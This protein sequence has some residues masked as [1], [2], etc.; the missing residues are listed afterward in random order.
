MTG[1]T[2]ATLS[3]GWAGPGQG[4][5]CWPLTLAWGQLDPGPIGLGQGR[6]RANPDPSILPTYK[7]ILSTTSIRN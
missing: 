5:F 7:T 1:S 4:H 3:R 2:V 6:A